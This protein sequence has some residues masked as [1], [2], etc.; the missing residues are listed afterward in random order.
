MDILKHE[1][2]NIR[3]NENSTKESSTDLKKL[4]SSWE[5]LSTFVNTSIKER[6][7]LEKYNHFNVFE[8]SKLPIMILNKIM[9]SFNPIDELLKFVLACEDHPKLGVLTQKYMFSNKQV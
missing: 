8:I 9:Q 2:S 6:L 1:K 7:K 4:M 3:T 5:V